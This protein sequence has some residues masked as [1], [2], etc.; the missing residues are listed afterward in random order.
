VVV[1]AAAAS[2]AWI[3]LPGP[4]LGADNGVRL[5]SSSANHKATTRSLASRGMDRL[6]P[7]H[8]REPMEPDSLAHGA[9]LGCGAAAVRGR[10]LELD[11]GVVAKASEP[12]ASP[13]F[14]D[15]ES[16]T[17][18][19]RGSSEGCSRRSS[20]VAIMSRN[21]AYF[22]SN[23]VA[24]TLRMISSTAWKLPSVCAKAVC[25][26]VRTCASRHPLK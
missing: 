16:A 7:P 23:A 1:T 24:F 2:G 15:W 6:L 17:E 18:E 13:P 19:R 10:F 11:P 22:S 20:D 8:S 9:A 12:P 3:A 21:A 14:L 5:D 26:E 25:R 4:H